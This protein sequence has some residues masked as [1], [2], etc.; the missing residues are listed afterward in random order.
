MK[1]LYVIIAVCLLM[2]I[3]CKKGDS[4]VM[5]AE[6]TIIDWGS[7][8]TDGCGWVIR[9]DDVYYSAD[10]LDEKYKVNNKIVIIEYEFTGEKYK[11]PFS[12]GPYYDIIK[13][14]RIKTR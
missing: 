4:D 12:F 3:S 9:V 8:A 2:G 14:K 6:A 5:K 11:C 10:Y 1:I 13:I 7:P